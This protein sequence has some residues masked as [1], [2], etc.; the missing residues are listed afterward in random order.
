MFLRVGTM[1]GPRA[2]RNFIVRVKDRFSN[3]F[4]LKKLAGKVVAES[5][6]INL[7][8][9]FNPW[10]ALSTFDRACNGAS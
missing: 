2:F 7:P 6:V 10:S 8:G 1:L 4:G 3:K 5:N 9:T